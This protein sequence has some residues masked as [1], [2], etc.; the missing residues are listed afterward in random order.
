MENSDK[1]LKEDDMIKNLQ[2]GRETNPIQLVARV[3][4]TEKGY[5]CWS[6]QLHVRNKLHVNEGN[7]SSCNK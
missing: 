1:D 7:A 4:A 2:K 6:I 3:S 5:L